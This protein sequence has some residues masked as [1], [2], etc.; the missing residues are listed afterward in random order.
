MHS[1]QLE[2]ES[3]LRDAL[4][5]AA[6]SSA[7]ASPEPA[8]ACIL[9]TEGTSYGAALQR[10]ADPVIAALSGFPGDPKGGTAYMI[11]EPSTR[12]E[13]GRGSAVKALLDAGISRVVACASSLHKGQEG[14]A[15][16][17]LKQAG[18]EISVGLLTSEARML[19]RA[20]LKWSRTQAPYVTLC[21]TGL[22]KAL[23]AA[24]RHAHDAVLLDLQPI[25]EEPDELF[26]DTTE[27]ERARRLLRFIIDP[28]LTIDPSTEFIASWDHDLILLTRNADKDRV[29]AVRGVGIAVEEL[30]PNS[31]E[32]W[33]D[34]L[35]TVA[36][37]QVLSL[38]VEGSEALGTELLNSKLVD[39]L[40]LEGASH[41]KHFS[42]T[43]LPARKLGNVEGTKI[44]VVTYLL[45]HEP[46]VVTAL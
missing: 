24:L 42:T 45:S 20:Y 21:S 40:I 37:M 35:R 44:P 19:N 7:L 29:D 46:P 3:K 43:D 27:Q 8:N 31:R 9:V 33:F 34:T 36:S 25:V 1:T 41:Y 18:V 17:I 32:G 30:A 6:Q 2:D 15:F 4:S 11:Q 14:L 12:E 26:L 28:E 23:R 39:E 13:A 10:G 22:P 16:E 38:L 5:L